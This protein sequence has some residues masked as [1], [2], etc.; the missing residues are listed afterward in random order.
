MDGLGFKE[1]FLFHLHTFIVIHLFVFFIVKYRHYV[2]KKEKKFQ[3]QNENA[4]R[5]VEIL[6]DW[7]KKKLEGIF[8]Y[9]SC[10]C[11]FSYISP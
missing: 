8:V 9:F 6:V 2:G 1:F 11:I 5:R 4:L 3:E 7:L 10:N